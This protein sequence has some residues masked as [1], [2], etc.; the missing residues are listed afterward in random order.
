VT[1]PNR[2]SAVRTRPPSGPDSGRTYGGESADERA[3]RR[4]RQLL[5]ACME[6]FGTVGYR[7]TKVERICTLAKVSTRHFYEQYP[8]KEAAF[9]DLYD[10]LIRK[11]Y[12]QVALSLAETES[13]PMDQRITAAFA[14]YLR[15][16]FADM[17]AAR[18]AFVEI[19]GLS[20]M[21]EQRRQE[22]RETLI[23]VIESETRAAVQRGEIADRDFRFAILS[24][25]G[26]A[27]VNV[28]DWAT[29]KDPRS[30]EDIQAQLL[31]LAVT[32]LG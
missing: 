15:P 27:T 1:D 6:L 10:Q 28:H 4:R 3:L 14:A 30:A 17:R 29:R 23:A 13:Q 24:L 18:V 7:A 22:Y 25:V 12:Q 26:A 19:V 8:G 32:L 5:G 16:L 31:A 2:S 9:V 21:I 20:P 11:S